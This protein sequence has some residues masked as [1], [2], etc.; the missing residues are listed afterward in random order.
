MVIESEKGIGGRD[1][2]KGLGVA[3][4]YI[5]AWMMVLNL[6]KEAEDTPDENERKEFVSYMLNI[7]K[8]VEKY[9][10]YFSSRDYDNKDAVLKESNVAKV[11]EIN[12]LVEE[13]NQA[14]PDIKSK[15]DIDRLKSFAIKINS[16]VRGK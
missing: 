10:D 2:E 7:L 15:Q 9:Q 1:V 5:N 13:F 3:P 14:L 16:L 8:P 12:R 6:L 11:A 4:D